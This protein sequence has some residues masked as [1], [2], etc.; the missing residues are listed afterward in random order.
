MG[1]NNVED[2]LGIPLDP[3]KLLQ[4][5]V[6]ESYLTKIGYFGGEVFCEI[7]D[8]QNLGKE[9]SAPLIMFFRK[10]LELIGSI[11]S[12][13]VN[14]Y[15]ETAKILLRTLLEIS[16]YIKFITKENSSQRALCFLICQ[17]HEKL[18][19]YKKLDPTSIQGKDF[20]GKL[21]DDEHF[22][23]YTFKQQELLK[24]QIHNLEILIEDEFYS[25]VEK[26]YQRMKELHPKSKP[27]WYQLFNGPKNLERLAYDL[28]FGSMYEV[29]YRPFSQ[30]IHGVDIIDGYIF[31]SDE[32]GK[33]EFSQIRYPYSAKSVCHMTLTLSLEILQSVIKYKLPDWE[34]R[35][36]DF[37]TNEIREFY[38]SFRE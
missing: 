35:Y 27:V 15:S 2:F 8:K 34:S 19:R 20:K 31:E 21:K 6:W 10:S 28:K 32:E 17:Y 16:L 38:I 12:L 14:F 25:D 37:Y 30:G 11:S 7:L 4:F 26:E 3:E 22:S 13:L 36:K 33:T 24:E 18:N 5:R 9:D 29:V 1:T 23:N